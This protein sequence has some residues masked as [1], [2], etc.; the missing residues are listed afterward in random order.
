MRCRSG[1]A[2]W[3]TTRQRLTPPST[4]A[5]CLARGRCNPVGGPGPGRPSVNAVLQSADRLGR[6]LRADALDCRGRGSS[7]TART[8]YSARVS[9]PALAAASSRRAAGNPAKRR[10]RGQMPPPSL[11]AGGDR[12]SPETGRHGGWLWLL[13]QPTTDSC[14]AASSPLVRV[15]DQRRPRPPA[16]VPSGSGQSRS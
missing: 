4:L 9:P 10:C 15:P 2:R 1:K 14:A 6:R 13:P 12:C 16:R 11:V 5:A 3:G 8:S 7:G